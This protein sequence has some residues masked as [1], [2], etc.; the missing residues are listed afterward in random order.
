M[1]FVISITALLLCSP[2]PVHAQEPPLKG[3]H[4]EKRAKRP[5]KVQK[6]KPVE[7]AND[8]PVV[9]HAVEHR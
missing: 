8:V 5:A 9:E 7:Q 2:V 6:P 3:E 1:R 4:K